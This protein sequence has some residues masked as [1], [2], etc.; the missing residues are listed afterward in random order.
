VSCAAVY[1]RLS[2]RP[3]N[4]YD[5]LDAQQAAGEAYAAKTWPGVP[6]RL[7]I[8]QGLS[9]SKDD[10][11]RP[12]Y[13]ALRADI[14]AGE[15]RC[16]WT[17][18]QSRLERREQHWFAFAALMLA[19]GITE[20]HTGREGVVQV[21]EAMAGIKA[22]LNADEIRKLKRRVNDQLDARAAAGVPSGGRTFG[23]R[24][25]GAREDRTYVIV[26]EQAE[27]VRW[28]AGKV[29]SGW[30]L[31]RIADVLDGQG[32]RGTHGGK[33]TPV[34]VRGWLTA[35]SIA[36]IRVHR[37]EKVGKGNWPPVL[38]EQVWREVGAVLSQPRVVRRRDGGTYPIGPAHTGPA[39]RKYLLTGGLAVCAVCL[40]PMVGAA[41][42]LRNKHRVRTKPYLL[43]H[44]SRGGR[45]CTGIMLPETEELVV[46]RLFTE[47][48]NRPSFAAALSAD[49]HAQARAELGAAL[50]AVQAE[51][52]EYARDAGA[53]R[54]TRAEWFALRPE[55][56]KREAGLRADLAAVPV[57]T[58]H[59]DWL[60]VRAA[61]AD[62]TLDEQ[63]AFLRRYVTS[64]TIARARPGT[65][66]FDKG[67]VNVEWRQV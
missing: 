7:Y 37:G 25:V 5:G 14:E 31:S 50:A 32:L 19:A 12:K 17:P 52:A 28:A 11:V 21:G 39:G 66:G 22:V 23:Y 20:L 63:R 36:G 10:V 58:G 48:E 38:D 51:R 41:K 43:C 16:L 57:P 26:P 18:E 15:V 4:H 8:E 13:N 47:L 49:Q 9:A 30:S 45:A 62:L 35:P 1:C 29:L 55:L 60:E 33:I 56:D 34:T 2:P 24:P 54:L 64:V 59:A 44:P 27:A 53:G 6:V 42:Q 61:W 40:A 46:R 67:R 65:Q 3:D